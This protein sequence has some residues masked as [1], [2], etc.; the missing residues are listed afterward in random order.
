MF[1]SILLK[2]LKFLEHY[3]CIKLINNDYWALMYA[4]KSSR[5]SIFSWT[6]QKILKN[7]IFLNSNLIFHDMKCN[8]LYILTVYI[9]MKQ[10]ITAGFATVCD[11][12]IDD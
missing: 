11:L 3:Y 12:N 10:K 4:V 9:K 7:L 5:K 2:Y 1:N 6:S 8:F